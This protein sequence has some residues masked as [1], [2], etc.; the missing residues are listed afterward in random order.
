MDPPLAPTHTSSAPKGRNKRAASDTYP[1]PP[2]NQSHSAKMASTPNILHRHIHRKRNIAAPIWGSDIASTPAAFTTPRSPSTSVPPNHTCTPINPFNVYKALLRHHNL[3]FQFAL[4]LPYSA[5]TALYAIDKEF[6]YRLNKFSVSLIHD[7]AKYHAP[8]ASY[9]FSWRVYPQLCIS[10]PML[11]P[12]D[13]REWLARDVPSFR[14]VGMVLWRESIVR[15]ILTLLGLEGLR[16]PAGVCGAVMKFWSVMEMKT[17][18]LR[19]SFLQDRNIWTDADFFHFQHF[20]VKLDM[21]FTDTVLGNGVG[22]LSHALLTQRSLVPLWKVLNGRLVLDYDTATDIVVRTYLGTDLDTDAY[23]W[24]DDETE[25]GV[26]VEESGLLS[27]EGWELGGKKMES[28]V[29]LVIME[30]IER[31]LNVQQYYLDFVLHGFVDE[32][33]GKNLPAPR[34]WRGDKKVTVQKE[35]WPSKE[36]REKMIADLDRVCGMV[37]EEEDDAMDTSG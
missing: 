24:L 17:Q 2:L 11:R 3:F 7:Y 21:R 5:I 26:P 32:E 27:K 8:L 10:D 33:T 36:L 13:R 16:L 31:G 4:R 15:S 37:N 25:N 35:G 19:I 9:I 12:M 28:V 18:R 30:S 1:P 22:G 14:W 34:L 20:L 29:D 6:H 23:S